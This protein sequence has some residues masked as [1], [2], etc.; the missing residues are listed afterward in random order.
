LVLNPKED[1]RKI[2]NKLQQHSE[3]LEISEPNDRKPRI[4]LN[5]VPSGLTAEDL[6]KLTLERNV[7]PSFGAVK[8]DDFLPLYRAGLTGVGAYGPKSCGGLWAY[9]SLVEIIHRH[10]PNFFFLGRGASPLLRHPASHSGVRS[11][12]RKF[13]IS[14]QKRRQETRQK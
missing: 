12:P 9:A 4:I 13:S 5:N 14:G 11:E 3:T 2:L 7:D 6:R 10:G 1:K 8:P